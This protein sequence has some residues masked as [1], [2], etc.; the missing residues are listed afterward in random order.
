M[1]VKQGAENVLLGCGADFSDFSITSLRDTT[2]I[3]QPPGDDTGF[4]YRLKSCAGILADAGFKVIL[5]RDGLGAHI[6]IS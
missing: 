6:E 3:H 4:S 5:L 2:V 1:T